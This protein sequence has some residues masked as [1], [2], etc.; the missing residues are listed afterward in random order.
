[1]AKFME[2]DLSTR[3]YRVS[4]GFNES[5]YLAAN[6]PSLGLYRLQEHVQLTV[7][8]IAEQK[9]GLQ[10]IHQRVGAYEASV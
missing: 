6:E 3:M 1:M 8:R 5:L 4:N 9:Q 2:P 10:E 7:P